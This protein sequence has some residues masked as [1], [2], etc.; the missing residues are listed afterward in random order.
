[1]RAPLGRQSLAQDGALGLFVRRKR[2][3]AAYQFDVLPELLDVVDADVQRGHAG[4]AQRISHRQLE[5]LRV[6]L[7]RAIGI[8]VVHSAGAAEDLHRHDPVR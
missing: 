2:F 4:Y 6:E 7:R 5:V 1:M 3:V 8:G